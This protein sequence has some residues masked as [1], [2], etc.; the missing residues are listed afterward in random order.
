MISIEILP[1]VNADHFFLLQDATNT[2]LTKEFMDTAVWQ[3]LKPV[4]EDQVYEK[5]QRY[6]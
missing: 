1:E 6:G 4:K 5:I 2:E 3:G